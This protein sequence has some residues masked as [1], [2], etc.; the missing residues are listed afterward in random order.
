MKAIGFNTVNS[1]ILKYSRQDFVKQLLFLLN[2]CWRDCGLGCKR[3][4][5]HYLRKGK[6][7]VAK[8]TEE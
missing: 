1:E 5:F 7:S 2:K 6:E 8:I 3:K 4:L